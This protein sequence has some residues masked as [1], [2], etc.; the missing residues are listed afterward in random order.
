MPLTWLCRSMNLAVTTARASA[1]AR[2]GQPGQ[3]LGDPVTG[4]R[5]VR[6]R[7]EPR[8]RIDDPPAAQDQV[9]LARHVG[10]YPQCPSRGI[11]GRRYWG[12]G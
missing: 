1:S 9:R 2:P 12:A 11:S 4:D 8:F 5:D 3:D 6:R 10:L 7:I